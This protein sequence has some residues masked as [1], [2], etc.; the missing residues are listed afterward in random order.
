LTGGRWGRRGGVDWGGGSPRSV[1]ESPQTDA[2]APPAGQASP[3]PVCLGLVC[4]LGADDSLLLPTDCRRVV[5]GDAVSGRQ[6]TCGFIVFFRVEGT[7]PSFSDWAGAM[8]RPSGR[9]VDGHGARSER[10]GQCPF[11]RDWGKVGDDCDSGPLM[12][13]GVGVWT[14][15][16][17]GRGPLRALKMGRREPRPKRSR[18]GA[19]GG[20]AAAANESPERCPMQRTSV[21][22]GCGVHEPVPPG[23]RL[24]GRPEGHCQRPA[25]PP[26]CLVGGRSP[27][28]Q[29]RAQRLPHPSQL[30]SADLLS[31]TPCLRA[32]FDGAHSDAFC[33]RWL[34]GLTRLS[35][36]L[37]STVLAV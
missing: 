23:P 35:S 12:S 32:A 16:L 31:W 25:T 11:G 29:R 14:F 24:T 2:R 8:G 13:S 19:S 9:R 6:G 36:L 27:S 5:G 34:L 1:S 30:S 10:P 21:G 18:G 7:R 37:S 4:S 33:A 17:L 20:H 15:S 28:K 22:C 3:T 26:W